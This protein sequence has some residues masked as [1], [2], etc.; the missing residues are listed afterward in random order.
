MYYSTED[1]DLQTLTQYSITHIID[2]FLIAI[3]LMIIIS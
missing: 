2:P 1:V 3:L